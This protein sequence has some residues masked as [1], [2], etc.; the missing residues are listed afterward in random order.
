VGLVGHRRMLLHAIAALRTGADAKA[1]PPAPTPTQLSAAPSAGAA[2]I[3]SPAGG[4]VGE[5]RHITVMFCDLVGSTDIAAGRDG[6]EWRDLVA[7]YLDTASAAVA[8]MGGK[9]AKNVRLPGGAGE[10]CR[11]CCAGVARNTTVIRGT[12]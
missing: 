1:S 6:E 8:E 7:A 4:A 10:R 12:H 3:S 11:A 5:R 2:A 9:V